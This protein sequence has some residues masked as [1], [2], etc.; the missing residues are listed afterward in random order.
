MEVADDLTAA[1]AVGAALVAVAEVGASSSA[2]EEP[3]ASLA[4][5][6]RARQTRAAQNESA[7]ADE[8]GSTGQTR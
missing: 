6:H 5:G 4:D 7:D 2:E 8:P 1:A 3:I